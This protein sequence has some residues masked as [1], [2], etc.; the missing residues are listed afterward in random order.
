MEFDSV[1]S[2][3]L[4]AESRAF[5]RTLEIARK[6]A[7][8]DTSVLLRGETG[9]GKEIVARFIHQHSRRADS[10]LYSISCGALPET[11]LESE[12]FGHKAGAY[13]GAARDRV[14]LFEQGALGT[15]LLDEI[16]DVGPAAQVKL[17]RVLQEREILR[18]GENIPRRVDIRILAATHRDLDEEV[19]AGRFR[20]DLL[21][22]LRVVEIEV[23]P[24]RSRVEDIR[25]L[26]VHFARHAASRLGFPDRGFESG[27]LELFERYS[28]PGNVRELINAIERAAVLGG[29]GRIRRSDLPSQILFGSGAVPGS[30]KAAGMSLAEVEAAHIRKVLAHTGGSRSK[31]ASVLGIGPSTLW[32]KMKRLGL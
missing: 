15:I 12:L 18:L 13:T 30:G 27:V 1:E 31:T 23:P 26:A 10:R 2:I 14:G 16:G 21:Y 28:W 6:V 25:P 24:L 5:R 9:S 20:R 7:P 4:R 17:L 3:Q 22:R 19:E 11:L 29:D 32:R 8:Y